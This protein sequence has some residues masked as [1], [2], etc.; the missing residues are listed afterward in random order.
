MDN[1][2][3]F[4]KEEF[5]E[6]LIPGTSEYWH[7]LKEDSRRHKHIL[8]KQI[9]KTLKDF[10]IDFSSH[11]N[12]YHYIIPY[13]NT[14]I[15]LWPSSGKWYDKSINKKGQG[16]RQLLVYMEILIPGEPV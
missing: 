10:D 15:D 8:S 6:S 11:N 14:M 3:G 4:S 5:E 1:I 2:Y 7:A 9:T 12:G 16:I 13:R